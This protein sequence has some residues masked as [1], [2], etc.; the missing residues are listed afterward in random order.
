M[1]PQRGK[2]R[3]RMGVLGLRGRETER[4][5][6]RQIHGMRTGGKNKTKAHFLCSFGRVQTKTIFNMRKKCV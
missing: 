3:M 2:E 1:K 6:E 5:R 4:G